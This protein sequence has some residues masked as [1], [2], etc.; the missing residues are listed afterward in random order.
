MPCAHATDTG[1][2]DAT[3]LSGR[4]QVVSETAKLLQ[5]PAQLRALGALKITFVGGEPFLHPSL[6][7]LVR[8]AKAAGLTTCVV[9]NASLLDERLL[10]ELR[11]SLDWLTVSIDASTDALHARIGRGR[12]R[13]LSAGTESLLICRQVRRAPPC[14]AVLDLVML[15]AYAGPL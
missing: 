11:D 2:V 13:E 7:A 8:A 5:V 12:A 4:V 9:T 10:Q 1:T 6:L 15:C 14:S 3:S